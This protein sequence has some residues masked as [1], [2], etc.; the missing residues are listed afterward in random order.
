MS[1][2]KEDIIF[3]MGVKMKN[4]CG[5]KFLLYMLGGLAV[6]WLLAAISPY[7]RFDWFLE[8]LLIFVFVIILAAMYPFFKFSNLSYLLIALFMAFH[9]VGAH[10][11]YTETPLDALI[12]GIYGFKRD[13]YDRIVHFMF[14]FLITYPV[15]EFLLKSVRV[16]KFWAGALSLSVIMAASAFYELIEMWVAKI[17]SPD[18]GTLFLG[19]Q[20]DPWDTQNDMAMAFYGSLII[21]VLIVFVT[22]LFKSSG[23]QQKNIGFGG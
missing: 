3:F 23:N 7:D 20:R 22:N 13:H 2:E 15:F 10:Y 1:S 14:G 17:V 21:I 16:S 4:K 8:N 11:S 19:T 12:K 9:L 6:I 18:L 5:N